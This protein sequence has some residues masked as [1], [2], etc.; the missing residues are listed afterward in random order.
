MNQGTPEAY[1]EEAVHSYLTRDGR[2][3]LE[4]HFVMQGN[5]HEWKPSVGIVLTS[6]FQDEELKNHCIAHLIRHGLACRSSEDIPLLAKRLNWP[7][8][9]KQL[10]LTPPD[11]RPD[12]PY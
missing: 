2:T 12:A 6:R 7:E 8:W 9:G 5:V 11:G 10:V 3:P 4:H 1:S